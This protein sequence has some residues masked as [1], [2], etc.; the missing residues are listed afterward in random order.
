MKKYIVCSFCGLLVMTGAYIFSYQKLSELSYDDPYG[1]QASVEIAAR[2]DTIKSSARLIVETYNAQDQTISRK[3]TAMPAMYLGLTR[4]GVLEKLDHY[5]DDLSIADLENGLVSFDLMYF[6]PDCLMLRKTYQPD[7]D[8]H[9]YYIKLSKGCITVYYSD[10]KTVYEYTDIDFNT[11]PPD[12]A[13]DVIGGMEIK[14]EKQL[15]D[16]LETYSS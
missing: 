5:M 13:A 11:L 7:E 6:S 15:Y 3:E 16:F 12:V 4:S 1:G 9:K 10:R 8:F 2:E 14:D